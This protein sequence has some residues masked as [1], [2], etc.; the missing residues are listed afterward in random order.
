MCFLKKCVPLVICWLGA[1]LYWFLVSSTLLV[2]RLVAGLL[3]SIPLGFALSIGC[4]IVG[5]T[6][7]RCLSFGKNAALWFSAFAAVVCLSLGFYRSQPG[8]RVARLLPS[9][10][11]DS[12]AIS[13]SGASFVNPL[14]AVTL[15]IS[16]GEL[17]RHS[18]ESGWR[19]V[20]EGK[21]PDKEFIFLFSTIENRS[22]LRFGGR[23]MEFRGNSRGLNLW[24]FYDPDL[25]TLAILLSK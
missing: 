14:W 4:L 25:E 10:P 8:V 11:K 1:F 6:F 2:P 21:A 20:G 23:C 15:R 19:L 5:F 7:S 13:V 17:L 22:Q 9:I 3:L 12:A 18:K 24:S 16:K